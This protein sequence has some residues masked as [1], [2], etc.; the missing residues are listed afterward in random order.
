MGEEKPVARGGGGNDDHDDD[1][2]DFGANLLCRRENDEEEKEEAEFRRGGGQPRGGGET[3]QEA[4]VGTVDVAYARRHFHSDSG[5][6]EEK[7]KR[8]TGVA[9]EGSLSGRLVALV[10][11]IFAVR[12]GRLCQRRF[13]RSR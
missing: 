8:E 9:C 6:E 4:Q 3:R 2:S 13:S 1:G 12:R 10:Y 5:Q 7:E 11:A